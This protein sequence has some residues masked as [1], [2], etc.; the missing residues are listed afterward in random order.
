MSEQL[1]IEILRQ[2]LERNQNTESQD[3]D[4]NRRF[5]GDVLPEIIRSLVEGLLWLRQTSDQIHT[6]VDQSRRT[7]ASTMFSASSPNASVLRTSASPPNLRFAG[8]SSL[9]GSNVH[10]SEPHHDYI[11]HPY[12]DASTTFSASSPDAT[13]LRTSASGSNPENTFFSQQNN[14]NDTRYNNSENHIPRSSLNF[15]EFDELMYLYH[16]NVQ[17]YQYTVQEMTERIEL[18][19]RRNTRQ[20]NMLLDNFVY[21]Y[22]RNMQEYNQ[23]TLRCLDVLQNLN[24]S[25]VTRPDV[26][27][28]FANP[29]ST[30]QNNTQVPTF[31]PTNAEARNRNIIPEIFNISR[32]IEYGFTFYPNIVPRNVITPQPTNHL[33]TPAQIALAT[34]EYT[35]QE[36]DRNLLNTIPVCPIMLEEFQ[37]GNNI[38]EIV[39][40]GHQFLSSSLER[41]F[42]RSCCCPICR[43]NLWDISAT[44]PN[45]TTRTRSRFAETLSPAE[46]VVGGFQPPDRSR[47]NSM[48]DQD[49]LLGTEPLRS[50]PPSSQRIM[51]IPLSTSLFS[52]T[53]SPF[54]TTSLPRSE[55]ELGVEGFQP[56]DQDFTNRTITIPGIVDVSNT[57]TNLES[58]AETTIRNW[59]SS[60]LHNQPNQFPNIDLDISYTVEYDYQDGSNNSV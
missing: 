19:H 54:R 23:V 9:S 37:V 32:P 2:H 44:E 52:Q 46:L 11:N 28:G 30:P 15:P 10:F 33:L 57:D 16:R 18:N 39:H 53:R 4:V 13:V 35:F 38:R 43:Y 3:R 20:Q 40:C 49:R 47:A 55:N 25:R 48:V 17:E 41:W 51:D 26:S 36:S 34:R 45:R 29:T 14:R 50:L 24:A 6:P 42:R 7:D 5:G 31:R 21:P 1:I 8:T 58:I 60:F 22:H 27:S 12:S 56:S 59:I